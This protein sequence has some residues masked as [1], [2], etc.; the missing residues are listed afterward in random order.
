MSAL[1]R[2][3]LIPPV[4][5]RL[6]ERYQ[7]YRR[8]GAS[9]FSAALGCLWTILAW[10]VFPLEHPRWQRIRDGHKA[11]YPHI[12][13]ARPR[14]L[15]PARY[16]I[17][18]LWLVMISSTKE[19][20]EPRWRSF[21]RLKD[22]RG[23]YHQWMD[24]LPERVRQKTT[25]LEKEKE[26][27]HLSNGA[28][29]F[30]LGVI[31]TFSLILALICITQPFNPLS[32]FIFLLLLWGV[33]LLVRRMPG[34]FSA[35]M[36]IVLSLTV[37]CRYIWWRYTSTLNWDDPVSLVCGLILL[38]AET[39]AW[40]V[41]VLGYFQVVWPLNRQPVPLPKEMSQWPTV[42]IFVPTY[43]EDLNVVKNTIYA[44]LGM[45]WPKDK[46][47][48]WILDDGG[49]ESFRQFARHVGVHYIARATHEHAK[50]G[51]INNA[52]KHAK[53]EFV[54]IF[55][56]DHVPTR[57]FLQMTMGWFLKEKQLAM[58]Q[59]PHHF[60]SPDPFERNLGRFR[61]T[62]NEGTLFYGLVQDGNDMW[63][64]TFF[65]GSCAV[66]RRKPLDEIGGIAV[67]TVTE[68]AHTS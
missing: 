6:S 57:S 67:E 50:A 18:T 9:P 30:I 60:F 27:G 26:L 44:S 29:R 35:L 17:Q 63:D 2:W 14:P 28:R 15:D 7:G 25:H 11:L 21:A 52:L 59:T 36:L 56:C 42:D 43:N 19:R 12:N 16:L 31:V 47:N 10:I 40:I 51:N 53:G 4:S 22:V 33:A 48:I 68:D 39:Y 3:L 66:I 13:A 61:K 20:H 24:T 8:H 62:P 38:F 46:L 58:M 64:A 45:D 34:R 1:S 32:Q 41:L 65:C 37:S 23:R 5:A 55:D 49:R 54:A